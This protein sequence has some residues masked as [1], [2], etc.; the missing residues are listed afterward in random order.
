MKNSNLSSKMA[1]LFF[2]VFS[3]MIYRLL[4]AFEPY[5]ITFFPFRLRHLQN[6]VFERI[7]GFFWQQKSLSTKF[8]F[9][10]REEKKN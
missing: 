10:V 3:F 1:L 8:V 4:H 9:N 2:K 6:M 7:N 5:V